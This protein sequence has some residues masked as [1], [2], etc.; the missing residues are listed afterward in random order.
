MPADLLRSLWS[1]P[2]VPNPPARTW[3][4]WALVG[5][6][7]PVAVLEGILRPDVVW[8][9]AVTLLAIGTVMTLLWRR[10]HPFAMTA[11][12]FGAVSV[13]TIAGLVSGVRGSTLGLYTMAVCLLLPYD[14]FR[15]GSGRSARFALS[16]LLVAGTTGMIEDYTGVGAAI[17]GYLVLFFPAVLGAEVRHLTTSRQRELDD[18]RRGER[19]QIAR[20]LHDTVAHHVSAIVIQAQAGLTVG[21]TRPRAATDALEVIEEEASRTLEE[22]RAIVGSLR[23]AG[24]AELAPQPDARD[25]ARLAADAP[26]AARVDV[27]LRG[28]VDGLSPAIQTAVYR[29]AQEAITN[30][31]RHARHATRIE[32][33]VDA[34]DGWVRLAVRDDGR[35]HPRRGGGRA[36]FGIVGMTERVT[37]LGGTFHAGPD[38][39]GWSVTASLPIDGAVA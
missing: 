3:R 32:V 27:E 39:E 12:V 16:I 34:V 38:S 28:D 5:L 11:L 6:L 37:L 4:D 22:M 7:I 29:L 17:G 21:P 18:V 19:E 35:G 2:A 1:E 10:T 13:V 26:G 9:P 36:G 25:I 30:A 15:W 33:S 14:L 23:H 24:E 31:R 20:E 8:R